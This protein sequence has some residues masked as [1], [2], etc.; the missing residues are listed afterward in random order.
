MKFYIFRKYELYLKR[1]SHI[2]YDW[3]K[4]YQIMN[5][6]NSVIMILQPNMQSLSTPDNSVIR[7]LIAGY[8]FL[9]EVSFD[10]ILVFHLMRISVQFWVFSLAWRNYM[11]IDGNTFHSLTN[12]RE[13]RE[14]K[15]ISA[16]HII[17]INFS[18][19]SVKLYILWHAVI[20]VVIRFQFDAKQFLPLNAWEYSVF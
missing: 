16:L 7:N 6:G 2:G 4:S 1:E 19:R 17:E 8:L 5:P 20:D 3:I 11:Y 13:S 9:I 10:T 14:N 18:T 12:M 15:F